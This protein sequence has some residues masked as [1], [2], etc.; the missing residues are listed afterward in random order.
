M[1]IKIYQEWLHDW[2]AKLRQQDW[3]I[4][5]FQDNFTAHIDPGDLI[6][7]CVKN[8]EPNLTAHIQPNDAGI[9][10]CFKAHFCSKFISQAIDHYDNDIAPTLIYEIDQLEAMCIADAAWCEVD[11]M[12]IRNCWQKTGILPE[13]LNHAAEI[14]T[15]IVPISTPNQVMHFPMMR[16]VF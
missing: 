14:P 10:H 8:F 5:L 2:D 15:P 6:N 7:I 9:I 3:H 13:V 1:T 16:R 4:L 11:T 12:T